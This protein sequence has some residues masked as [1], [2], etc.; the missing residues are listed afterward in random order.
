MPFIE[1]G[2]NKSRLG[3]LENIKELYITP[4]PD[5]NINVFFNSTDRDSITIYWQIKDK[6]IIFENGI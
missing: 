6:F 3:F 5:R 1:V 2:L 4:F